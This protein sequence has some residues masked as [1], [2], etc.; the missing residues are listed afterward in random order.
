MRQNGVDNV[1]SEVVDFH[2]RVAHIC[3]PLYLYYLH[4]FVCVLE[5]GRQLCYSCIVPRWNSHFTTLSAFG[6]LKELKMG[7]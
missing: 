5:V 4:A 1:C 3:P 2:S 6:A 7:G